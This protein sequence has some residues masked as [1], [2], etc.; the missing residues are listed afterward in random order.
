MLHL[1][2]AKK[3]T[4]TYCKPLEL[5]DRYCCHKTTCSRPGSGL[6]YFRPSPC[7]KVSTATGSLAGVR[8]PCRKDTESQLHPISEC[9]VLMSPCGS[10]TPDKGP[11]EDGYGYVCN[12]HT[13]TCRRQAASSCWILRVDRLTHFWVHVL[14]LDRHETVQLLNPRKSNTCSSSRA[15]RNSTA[16]ERVRPGMQNMGRPNTPIHAFSRSTSNPER[17]LIG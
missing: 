4:W 2:I 12:R 10:C 8:E 5:R 3:A 7:R 9:E 16:L 11:Y 17:H 6:V 1:L 15:W 14:L 13:V